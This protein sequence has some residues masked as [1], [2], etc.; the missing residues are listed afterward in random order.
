MPVVIRLLAAGTLGAV[1]AFGSSDGL[2]GAYGIAVSMMMAMTTVLAGLI[3]LQWAT[4]PFWLQS[5]TGERLGTK[6]GPRPVPD[7]LECAASHRPVGQAVGSLS[8][9]QLRDGTQ[10]TPRRR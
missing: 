1:I 4:T 9:R 5:S 3:A 8:H 2:G 6:H 10:R 7:S